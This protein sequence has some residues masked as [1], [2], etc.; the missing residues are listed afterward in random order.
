M[1]QKSIKVTT[2][3]LKILSSFLILMLVLIF[4]WILYQHLRNPIDVLDQ[5]INAL[6][7][8]KDSIY[9]SDI[10][11]KPRVYHDILLSDGA[12]TDISINISLPLSIPEEGLP[13]TIILGG[14]EIGRETLSYIQNPGQNIVVIYQYPYHPRYWYIGTALNE[15]S[16]IRRAVLGVPAQVIALTHWVKQQGW[17]KSKNISI[18]GYSFGALFI[19]AVY[20]L[21]SVHNLQLKPGTI[22]YGGVDI[23]KLLEHN[24][25]MIKQP[26]RTFTAWIAAT[27][28]HAIEP[29][30]H[31][32]YMN[33]EFL[34]INGSKDHQIPS[35]CWKKLHKEIPEPKTIIILD[36]GH[37]HPDKVELTQ[38]LVRL[39][40]A[41]LLER[42]V[43]N[44]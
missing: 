39:S 7:V 10:I 33:N 2:L 32:P 44:P 27:A 16:V 43:I 14:L 36:E 24:L 19:P 13:V 22:I 1:Q 35:T 4:L 26:W 8:V 11:S 40:Q 42:D 38:H 29:S 17:S 41:W 23:Y 3:V 12:N 6:E 37:M 28:I 9:Y 20:H 18:L 30:L 34:L 5:K 21:A 25:V 31:L 15:I